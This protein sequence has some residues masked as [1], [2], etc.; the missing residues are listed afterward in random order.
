MLFDTPNF[1][2]S[3]LY[4]TGIIGLHDGGGAHMIE[5][6]RQMS[7]DYALMYMRFQPS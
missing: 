3:I 2:N 5:N 7:C 4:V 1:Y 6:R